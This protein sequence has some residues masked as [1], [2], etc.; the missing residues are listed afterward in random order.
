MLVS[1]A[2]E[3]RQTGLRKLVEDLNQNLESNSLT[4]LQGCGAALEQALSERVA[5]VFFCAI[6]LLT[7][8]LDYVATMSTTEVV[9]AH[10]DPLIMPMYSSHIFLQVWNRVVTVR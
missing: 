1:R 10:L 6:S 7:A 5:S 4:I 8:V 2:R 9:H 3:W